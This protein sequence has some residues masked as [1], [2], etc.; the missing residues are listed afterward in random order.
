MEYVSDFLVGFLT[1]QLSVAGAPILIREIVGNLFG[2]ACAFLGMKRKV[3]A[4]PVGIIGNALLFT[5]F[6]G[7]VFH[8]P[9]NLDLYGQAGRQ[10]MFIVVSLYG[11]F[12]WVKS[13]NQ[14]GDEVAIEPR[15]ATAS[16]RIGMI[17]VA[18][19]AVDAV[20]VPLLLKG[21]Y[22]PSAALYLFYGCFVIWGFVSWVRLEHQS[23]NDQQKGSETDQVPALAAAE[24]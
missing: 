18:I 13:R 6:L 10:V 16:E 12:S 20:G 9:Q 8:T 15:W 24:R 5:V 11:W 1:A 4:W 19:F 17:T 3:W 23:D 2:L 21:G 14:S 7:G 22:Y